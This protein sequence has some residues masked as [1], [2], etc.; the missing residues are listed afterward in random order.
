MAENAP[1]NIEAAN[2]EQRRAERD[3]QRRMVSSLPRA[4]D[5]Q[6]FLANLATLHLDEQDKVQDALLTL[7]DQGL[8]A[9]AAV[10]RAAAILRSSLIDSSELFGKMVMGNEVLELLT[11][12]LV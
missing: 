1:F 3:R 4:N 7:A 12:F 5:T 2:P 6:T 11:Y 9:P 10:E 8:A